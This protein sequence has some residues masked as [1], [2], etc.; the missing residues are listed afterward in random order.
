[1]YCTGRLILQ[2]SPLPTVYPSF[3]SVI[4][5]V[6]VGVLDSRITGSAFW[7]CFL[8]PPGDLDVEPL[9]QERRREKLPSLPGTPAARF[10]KH[11]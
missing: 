3:C 1:M 2:A 7:F 8:D 6:G 4:Y 9:V 5:T 10:P 11:S